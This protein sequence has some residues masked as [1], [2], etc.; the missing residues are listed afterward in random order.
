MIIIPSTLTYNIKSYGTQ[1]LWHKTRSQRIYKRY[2]P[3][4]DFKRRQRTMAKGFQ[5]D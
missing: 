4:G 5:Y 1:D 3:Q 2:I